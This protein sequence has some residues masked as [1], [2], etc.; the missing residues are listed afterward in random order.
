[1]PSRAF[2]ERK[3]YEIKT[4]VC[5]VGTLHEPG[6]PLEQPRSALSCAIR[7]LLEISHQILQ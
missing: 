4:L 1:M 2:R 6:V 5:M 7:L 3:N